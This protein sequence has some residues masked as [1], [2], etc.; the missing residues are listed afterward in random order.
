[1]ELV[2]TSI[3]RFRCSVAS[4][5]TRSNALNGRYSLVSLAPKAQIVDV[6]TGL[7]VF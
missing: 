6:F 4:T 5:C 1:M 3:D 7:S 2:G